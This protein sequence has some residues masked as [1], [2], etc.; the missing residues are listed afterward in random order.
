MSA[1]KNAKKKLCWN[2]EGAVSVNADACPY[3]GV[4]A[5]SDTILAF[6]EQQKTEQQKG[7]Q[8]ASFSEIPPPLFSK[9]E[10]ENVEVIASSTVKEFDDKSY[11][12]TKHVVFSLLFLLGAMV[13]LL[14]GVLLVLF[15][16]QGLLTLSWNGD[17]WFMY[18]FL[19]IPLFALGVNS[20]TKVRT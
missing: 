19:S 12:E 8:Q 5:L 10:E 13:L 15:S 3:C 2:C 16:Q 1:Q 11:D 9:E 18:V 20:L 4:A 7:S 6:H 14:F 17:Y